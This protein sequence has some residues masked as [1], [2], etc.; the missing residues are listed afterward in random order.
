MRGMQFLFECAVLISE[1]F[2]KVKMNVIL[3]F[4]AICA[5]FVIS[6]HAIG[7][8]GSFGV[9]VG[10]AKC[11]PSITTSSGTYAM[12]KGRSFYGYLDQ[13]ILKLIKKNYSQRSI[14]FR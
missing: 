10:S 1:K 13:S 11:E 14:L 3:V 7:P 4:G 9:G 12:H 8:L 5:Y 2:V 6:I